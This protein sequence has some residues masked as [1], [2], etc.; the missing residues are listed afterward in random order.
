MGLAERP[1]L[2]TLMAS[3]HAWRGGSLP[4]RREELYADAVELLLNT[5]ERQRMTLD[6]TGQPI[7]LQPSLAEWLRVDR[8][9]VRQVLEELAFEA[10]VAQPDLA[11][12]ADV[13]EGKLVGRLLHLS[14]NPGADA[15]QLLAYL[16]DRAG[17]LVER[18]M[19]VYTFPHRTFQEYLAAC[20]LTGGSFPE[21]AAELG[22]KEPGRWREVILLAGAKA[23]RGAVASVWHLADDLCFQEPDGPGTGSPD[24]WGALLAGQVLME[25]A[26]LARVSGAN[27][28]KLDRVRRWLVHLMRIDIFPVLERAAAGRALAT[29]GDPRFDPAHWYLPKEPLLGFVE[30]PEGSFQMG[31]D[32]RKVVLPTFYMARYPVTVAQFRAFVEA[33]G[34]KKA[35]PYSW[36]GLA[37]DPVIAVDWQDALDYCRW[38]GERLRELAVKRQGES[39]SPWGA[40]A[41]SDLVACLPSEAEWEKAARGME[42]NVYPW[43]EEEDPNRA[44][45]SKTGLLRTSAVGCF[46]GGISHYGC[47]EMSGNVWEWTREDGREYLESASQRLRVVRG[48]A[49][50]SATRSIR[51]AGRERNYPNVQSSNIGFRV[52]L[53]PF[54][55]D[56]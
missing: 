54:H 2:L 15:A 51:C 20:Y 7:Q 28:V 37:N 13:D 8:Q 52:A 47:E 32:R 38:L 46:S 6:R 12:T 22:R 43:G 45:Y 9:E 26:D 41:R 36:G 33:S 44:N 29:L 1:L 35:H 55:S 48:G 56:L 30:V 10:H 40:L 39:A 21:E 11:G 42:G 53:S 4:E 17:L 19:G 50:H 16:R 24:D 3:L 31:D 25:S 23:A 14:R 34:Y 49:F 27:E 5:W 18:G